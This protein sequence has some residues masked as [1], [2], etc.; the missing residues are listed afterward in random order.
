M[1]MTNMNRRR[2]I[3]PQED[4]LDRSQS[5]RDDI[6]VAKPDRNGKSRRVATH[7]SLSYR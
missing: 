3:H 5:R 6:S 4:P 2:M 7:A 1:K